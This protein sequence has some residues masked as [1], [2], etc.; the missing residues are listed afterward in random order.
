LD[1]GAQ[2]EP[3]RGDDG[4]FEA[5]AARDALLANG[6]VLGPDFHY[7]L[8]EGAIHR[9]SAW[10]ARLPQIFQFLF[11]PEVDDPPPAA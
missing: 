7:F 10:A 9:E 8:D 2:D 4:M 5:I 3:G 6:Y 11:P 1:S